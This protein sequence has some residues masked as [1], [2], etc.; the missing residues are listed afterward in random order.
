M[1]APNPEREVAPPSGWTRR[2]VLAALVAVAL[3]GIMASRW[4]R[5]WIGARNTLPQGDD[6]ELAAALPTAAA[7]AGAC[8]GHQLDVT[9]TAEV[10]DA[11]RFVTGFDG[12]LAAAIPVV[13]RFADREALERAGVTYLGADAT[14]REA[15]LRTI[16]DVSVA[17]RRSALLAVV[18]DHERDRRLIHW[19]A[20]GRLGRLY[21]GTPPAWRRRGYVQWP[22]TGGDPRAYTRAGRVAEC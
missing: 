1:T 10:A 12:E 16:V 13:A 18:S 11:L 22:G 8:C 9:E 7:F 5:G 20:L 17:T 4:L 15:I 14:T 3:V 6:A 19:Y 2:A 21:P